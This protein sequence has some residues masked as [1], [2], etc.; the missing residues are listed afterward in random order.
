[1][2]LQS[3]ITCPKCGHRAIEQMP[4]DACQYFYECKLCGKRLKPIPGDCCVFCSYGTLKCPP[5]QAGE[6]C[7]S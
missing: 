3:T 7:C 5:M 6:F 1:M 4:T 2:V